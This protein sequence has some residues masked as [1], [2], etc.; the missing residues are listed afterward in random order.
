MSCCCPSTD[1]CQGANSFFSR[2]SK[3]YAKKFRRRG[4]EKVQHYI[5]EG[6]KREAIPNMK[7]LDIGCGVGSLHLTLLKDGGLSS[8]GVDVSEGMLEQAKQLASSLGLSDRTAYHLGDFVQ[9]S[10]SLPDGDVTMLDKVVC[11]YEDLPAL[12]DVSTDKTKY[13]YALSYPRDW[14]PVRAVFKIQIAL[15]KLL[16]WK[17]H[18]FWHNWESMHQRIRDRGFELAFARSTFVWHIAVYRRLQRT[19]A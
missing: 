1:A 6:V 19:A 4:L 7:I 9:L 2:W 13:V 8:V 11:C 14:L 12:I 3:S 17:F 10:N 16:R 18:P 5:L 15:A